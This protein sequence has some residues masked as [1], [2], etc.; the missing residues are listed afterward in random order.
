MRRAMGTLVGALALLTLATGCSVSSSTAG[1]EPR[2][3]L[4]L[5]HAVLAGATAHEQ[6]SILLACDEARRVQAGIIPT[7][8]VR[9]KRGKW[10]DLRDGASQLAESR[11]VLVWSDLIGHASDADALAAL[12]AACGHSLV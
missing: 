12:V 5:P 7:E 11:A 10:I 1:P 4:P 3:G 8:S 9:L 2:P 6:A